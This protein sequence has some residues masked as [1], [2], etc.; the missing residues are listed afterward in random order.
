MQPEHLLV[1]EGEGLHFED[2]CLQLVEVELNLHYPDIVI[3]YKQDKDYRQNQAG[4]GL[5]HC[6]QERIDYK[7]LV[8]IVEVEVVFVVVFV[9][10]LETEV[11]M[12]QQVDYKHIGYNMP[13]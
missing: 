7:V 12:L 11:D 10:E 1:E 5:E 3:G 6:T 4:F 13:V 8:E 9:A 2:W